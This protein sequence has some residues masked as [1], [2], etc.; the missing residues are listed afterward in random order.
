MELIKVLGIGQWNKVFSQKESRAQ[1]QSKICV[2]QEAQK[3]NYLEQFP[4]QNHNRKKHISDNLV[5]QCLQVLFVGNACFWTTGME[6]SAN[7]A[8]RGQ[9][10][11]GGIFD[12]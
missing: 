10:N 9:I 12:S 11:H 4:V 8:H 7:K 5:V 2:Y 6:L 3:S 1:G